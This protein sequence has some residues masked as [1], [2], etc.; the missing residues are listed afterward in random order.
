[1]VKQIQNCY[2]NKGEKGKKLLYGSPAASKGR[3]AS[4]L[5]SCSR[6]PRTLLLSPG[7]KRFGVSPI[8]AK[9]PEPVE[10]LGARNTQAKD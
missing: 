10:H 7:E 2:K 5:A 6:K 3:F 8:R 1:M 4:T 9:G